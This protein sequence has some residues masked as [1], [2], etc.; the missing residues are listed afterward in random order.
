[1]IVEKMAICDFYASVY[2][3]TTSLKT[4]LSD[5]SRERLRHTLDSALPELYA[6]ILVFSVKVQVYF[7]PSTNGK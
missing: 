6:A 5:T 3:E 7:S 2:M 1:M 4:T